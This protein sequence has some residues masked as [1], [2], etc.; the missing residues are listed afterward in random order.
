MESNLNSANTEKFRHKGHRPI[1]LFPFTI[2]KQHGDKGKYRDL[3]KNKWHLNLYLYICLSS[4]LHVA[5][6]NKRVATE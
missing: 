3:I 1:F 5:S 6:I 4:M 2:T